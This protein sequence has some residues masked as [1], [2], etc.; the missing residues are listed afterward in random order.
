MPAVQA[1]PGDEGGEH[2][3]QHAQH[4]EHEK[5]REE[6]RNVEAELCFQQAE[7]E[8]GPGTGGASGK[9]GNHGGNER[10]TAADAKPRHEIGQ[11]GGQLQIKQRLPARSAVKVKQVQQVMITLLTTITLQYLVL[12]GLM[13]IKL[14]SQVY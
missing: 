9:F 13:I 7:G 14:F 2:E 3:N 10:Q 12:L 1:E 8:A 11:R 6:A 5:G 4:R